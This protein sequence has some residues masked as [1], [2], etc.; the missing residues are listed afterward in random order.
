QPSQPA[1]D[2]Y[3]SGETLRLDMEALSPRDV[4]SLMDSL[5]RPNYFYTDRKHISRLR[6]DLPERSEQYFSSVFDKVGDGILVFMGDLNEDVL[7]RELTRTL[8]DFKTQKKYAQ[9]P[10]VASPIASGSVTLTA[11][12]APGVVGG[13][14]IGVNVGMTA[15]IP[16]SMENYMSFKVACAVIHK[17]LTA[18]LADQGAFAEFSERLELFPAERLS[19]FINC[20]PCRA[21]GL[22]AGVTPSDPLELLDAVRTVTKQLGDLQLEERDIRAYKDLLLRQMEN[23][24]GDTESLVS[25]VLARY[26]EGKDLVT[27]YKT[28]IQQVS[29]ASVADILARLRAGAEVEYIII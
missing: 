17:H 11:E 24:M 14:E 2:Y 21:A 6:D 26:S 19:L 29:V 28:A 18:A 8:G 9:R 4:N 13:G 15:A 12:S 1:F 23:R 3:K 20:R 22:P 7:K 27:D 5:M 25:D 10:R 16:F